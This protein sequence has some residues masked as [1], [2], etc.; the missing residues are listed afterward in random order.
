M[1]TTE[2]SDTKSGKLG[3]ERANSIG[4][5]FIERYYEMYNS[6]I[7]DLYKLYSNEASVS[8]GGLKKSEGLKKANGI[9]SIKLL[10]EDLKVDNHNRIIIIDADIQV[11]VG[12]SILIIVNGEWSKNGSPYYQFHQTFVLCKGAT[13]SNFDIANDILRFI[14]YD[15]KHEL[16]KEPEIEEVKE[17]KQEPEVEKVEKVESVETVEPIE[18]AEA[19]EPETH[20]ESEEKPED[21]DAS[22]PFSW[23]AL[24]ATAKDKSPVITRSPSITKPSQP[25]P[26][27]VPQPT[28]NGKFRK[29]DW[30]P[31]YV[32]GCE[33][34]PEKE[35]KDH[36]TKEF[37]EIKFFRQNANIALVDFLHREGQK[38]ALDAHKTKVKDSVILL[39]IRES[40]SGK[41]EVKKEKVDVKRKVDKKPV[42][43]VKN[44]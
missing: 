19:T 10:F 27:P 43:K 24:A 35:L 11:S 32:R 30:F 44:Q 3:I 25:K 15:Y 20:D 6:D 14:D 34:I 29:E 41:K 31:I 42:K 12:D 23:A 17:V 37:G 2:V 4:W 16:L 9:D 36:L 5:L 7:T 28:S 18:T 39:E 8:H 21:D 13:D 33:D 26:Q 38:K 22:G 40:K 1:T